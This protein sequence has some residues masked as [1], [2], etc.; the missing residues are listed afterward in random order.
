[1]F[2]AHSRASDYC[3]SS[4]ITIIRKP[5]PK[6]KTNASSHPSWPVATTMNTSPESASSAQQLLEKQAVSAISSWLHQQAQEANSIA[7]DHVAP[8]FFMTASSHHFRRSCPRHNR[9]HGHHRA[10]PKVS[11][12]AE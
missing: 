9:E 6:G 7:S 5:K 4:I 1:M 3:A 12:Q 11:M 8:A 2:T 10:L